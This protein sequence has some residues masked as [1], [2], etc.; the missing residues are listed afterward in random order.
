MIEI[1][2]KGISYRIASAKELFD[3]IIEAIDKQPPRD[4]MADR[5]DYLATGHTRKNSRKND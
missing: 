5:E 3:Y 2:R 1:I 4:W